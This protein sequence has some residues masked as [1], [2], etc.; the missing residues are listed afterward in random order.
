MESDRAQPNKMGINKVC[1]F[2]LILKAGECG[3]YNVTEF[4]TTGAGPTLFHLLKVHRT[5]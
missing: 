2:Y 1:F 3:I 4:N 5:P